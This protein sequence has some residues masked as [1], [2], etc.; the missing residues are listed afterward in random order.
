MQSLSTF[1]GIAALSLVLA[2]AGYALAAPDVSLS[3]AIGPGRAAQQGASDSV[4]AATGIVMAGGWKV[5]PGSEVILSINSL[6]GIDTGTSGRVREYGSFMAGLSVFPLWNAD[7]KCAR[8]CLDF[9]RLTLS[10]GIGLGT[11]GTSSSAKWLGSV[12]RDGYALA[13]QGSV[14]WLF[15]GSSVC[16]FGLGA[17]A[18]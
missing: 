16:S 17:W 1:L 3:I 12:D 10:I 15:V 13:F 4:K 18:I 7:K 9:S 14:D 2:P 6:S 5:T 8:L 11:S